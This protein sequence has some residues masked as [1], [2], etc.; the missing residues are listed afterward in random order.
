MDLMQQLRAAIAADHERIEQLP[1]FR[2]LTAGETARG[3]YLRLLRVLRDI[4]VVLEAELTRGPGLDAVHHAGMNRADVLAADLTAL[5]ANPAEPDAD[6]P[7]ALQ[8][9]V[10]D[11]TAQF[12][13]WAATDPGKL[14]GALYVFEGSRMGSQ[15]IAEPLS[16]MLEVPLQAGVGLD[17]HLCGQETRYPQWQRFKHSLTAYAAARPDA[18]AAR[19]RRPLQAGTGLRCR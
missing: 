9:E 14:L 1:F 13:T 5:G 18:G 3:P 11:L 15:V 6:L 16:R 8:A 4:H 17:Y 7:A 10:T 19:R 2:S 12:R